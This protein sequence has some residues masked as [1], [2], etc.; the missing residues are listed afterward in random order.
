[1]LYTMAARNVVDRRTTT[2]IGCIVQ[3]DSLR[4]HKVL[5]TGEVFGNRE[6][7]GVQY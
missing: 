1:M 2:I 4:T 7:D 6:G 3:S 5:A